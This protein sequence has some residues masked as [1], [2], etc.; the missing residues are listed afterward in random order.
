MAIDK[1]MLSF[2]IFSAE[3]NA[4]PNI[5]TFRILIAVAQMGCSHRKKLKFYMFPS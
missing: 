3:K 1:R 5:L 4:I 2:Q